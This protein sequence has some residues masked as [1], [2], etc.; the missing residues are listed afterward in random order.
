[1][2]STFS[3]MYIV[4][5]TRGDHVQF[6]I[7]ECNGGD[8]FLFVFNTC[9]HYFAFVYS[10]CFLFLSVGNPVDGFIRREPRRWLYKAGTQEMA[11]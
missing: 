7:K 6:Q 5:D 11:L 10:R 8:F 9:I 2:A 3:F 1:M 4:L